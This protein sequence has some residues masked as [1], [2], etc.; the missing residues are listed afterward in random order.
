MNR[1][2]EAASESSLYVP[3]IVVLP[4]KTPL[5]FFEVPLTTAAPS[6]QP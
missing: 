5:M 2:F 4:D 6:P 3:D 1:N